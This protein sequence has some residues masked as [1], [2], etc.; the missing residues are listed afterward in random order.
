[1]WPD[2][3]SLID[4]GFVGVAFLFGMGGFQ[5]GFAAQVAHLITMLALG[6]FLFYAYP[7]IFSYLGRMFRNLDQTVMMWII[8]AA[9]AV[10]SFLCFLYVTKLVAGMLKTQISDRSDRFYGFFFG[11][12]RG[13]LFALLALIFVAMLGSEE[14]YD[15]LR[16]KSYTGKL[17]CYELVPRIQPRVNKSTVGDGFDRMRESLMQREEAGLPDDY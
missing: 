16:A 2:W 8:L 11:F 17:V 7:A 12:F 5:K 14:F 13:A 9:L 15:K 10:L 3:L 4:V 1:M 6:A